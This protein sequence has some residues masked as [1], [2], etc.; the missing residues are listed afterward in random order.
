MPFEIKKKPASPS[1]GF[2]KPKADTSAAKPGGFLKSGKAALAMMEKAQAEAE[3]RKN[4][5]GKAFRFWLKPGDDA[6]LT[7]LDGKIDPATGLLDI[8][9]ANEHRIKVGSKWEDFICIEDEEPCPLCAAGEKRAF[10]GYLTVIDHRGY[11]TEKDGKKVKVE[12]ARRLY[13]A[14]TETLKQ[15]TKIAEKRE[16][17]L[18]GR[19]FE[20][21]R[22]GD[23][24]AAVGD[25]FDHVAEHSVEEIVEAFGDEGQ[26]IDYNAELPYVT[27]AQMKE[28]G[29]G[30]SVQ[31]LGG[32]FSKIGGKTS[33]DI[34]PDE[35]P[36]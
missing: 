20:V 35:K 13:V 33:D 9:Y 36:W 21:S 24:K 17:G 22:T 34:D 4:S 30:K 32:G 25:L 12:H 26:P 8:P 6:H 10:V 7:F 18:V 27:A 19:T 28:L 1:S 29:I 15:L 3:M 2:G 5:V 23:K 14:K 16:D 31:T 11:E